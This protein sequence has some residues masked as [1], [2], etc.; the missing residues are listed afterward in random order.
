MAWSHSSKGTQGNEV[1]SDFRDVME[2]KN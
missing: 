1:L 2:K